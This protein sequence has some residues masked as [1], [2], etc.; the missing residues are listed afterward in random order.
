MLL[1]VWRWPFL[2][3]FYAGNKGQK[4]T[5]NAHYF[6]YLFKLH[7]K[8]LSFSFPYAAVV[9]ERWW[10][11]WVQRTL[12]LNQS[13]N[14]YTNQSV[15]WACSYRVAAKTICA[16]PFSAGS[17]KD[18]LGLQNQNFLSQA[19]GCPVDKKSDYRQLYW[20]KNRLQAALLITNQTTD[21]LADK[22]SDF[23]MSCWQ[24]IRL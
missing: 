5:F 17:V 11:V 19:P 13:I 24:K 14:Q 20:Q 10:P 6:L 22:K 7:Q 15:K 12:H 21:S 1:L 23:R 18:Y 4:N 3:W 8:Y 16:V 9:V 2:V